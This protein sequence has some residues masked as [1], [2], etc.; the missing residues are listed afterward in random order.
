MKECFVVLGNQ[1]FD[2]KNLKNFKNTCEFFIQEDLGLCTYFKHHKQKIYYFLASMR[3]YRDYLKKNKFKVN[4]INLE[5]NIADYKNYFEGL[6]FFLKSK[7]INKINIFEI[8]DLDFRNKFEHFCK[9]NKVNLIFHTSPMFLVGRTEYQ[10][11]VTGKKPQLASFYSNIR[12]K[13]EIFVKDN[14]P[15]GDK[16]SFDEDNRKRVPK[17]Y[18]SPK[19]PTFESKHYDDLK[20]I[21][22]KYFSNHFGDLSRNIIFPMNF[23]DSYKVLEN[24][25]NEKLENFGHYED[26]VSTKDPYINHSLISAPLNMGL[27]TPKDILDKLETISYS[28][29]GINNYEGFIRQVF[30]W[31]EFMRYLNI[32]YYKDFNKGNFFG[33]DRKL[34]KHWYE[35]TTN[36]PILNDMILNLKQSGYVHHIPRLMIICNIMNLSGLKP[37]EVYKW[38]METFIDSSDWVMTPNVYGMGLFSDGGIFATKPYLC[39]SNYLLKMSNYSRGEWTQTMDGLYWN[40][41]SKNKNYFKTNHRLSMMYYTVIKMDKSKI[42]THISNAKKF[43]T[44]YT[45]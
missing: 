29:V 33:N 1:L 41:I 10:D 42:T 15:I 22:N 13:F 39:G 21:I 38:F 24:F 5:K 16:W 40:F 37:S 3:E 8:E 27:L 9:I 6:E 4:Y 34:S 31:R 23:K 26:F 19:S 35:G 20:K 11:I 17:D 30:G 28:Q 36:I 18:L 14:K 7:N 45:R 25:I 2:K 44:Q 43:I 32:N 12:R